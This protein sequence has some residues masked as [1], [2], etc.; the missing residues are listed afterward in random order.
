M[1]CYWCGAEFDDPEP[2]RYRENLDGENGWQE[3]YVGV[4][5]WCGAEEIGEPPPLRRF[6]PV[7]PEGNMGR[8]RDCHNPAISEVTE[9]EG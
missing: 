4:C 7:P 9:R 8:G 3:F 1:I 6:A 2:M 5:P